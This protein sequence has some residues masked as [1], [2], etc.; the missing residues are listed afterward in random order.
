MAVLVGWGVHVFTVLRQ[1]R[2]YSQNLLEGSVFLYRGVAHVQDRFP[3]SSRG[4]YH[5]L[6]SLH[7][8]KLVQGRRRHGASDVGNLGTGI[9]GI[10]F[11]KLVR[12]IVGHYRREKL[13]ETR[14]ARQWLLAYHQGDIPW[15]F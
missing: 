1:C 10:R 7:A 11:L 12:G 8:D 4:V 5:G 13:C 9:Y 2:W 15:E 14:T 3:T 6:Q